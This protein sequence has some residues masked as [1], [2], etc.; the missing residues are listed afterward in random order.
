MKDNHK[1][2]T[3]ALAS[4]ILIIAVMLISSFVFAYS[5]SEHMVAKQMNTPFVGMFMRW[6]SEYYLAIAS[7]GYP[8]GYPNI[9]TFPSLTATGSPMPPKIAN[10][11]WAFFPFYPLAMAALAVVFKRFLTLTPSLMVSGVIVSNIAFFVSGY[12][13]YKL[14]QKLFG[15]RIALISTVF[16]CFWVGGV[17]FSAIYSEAL[18]M[19]LTLG[20][21]YYLEENRLSNAVLL[22]FLALLRSDGFLIFIP[23]LVYGLLQFR[24]SKPQSFKLMFSSAVVASPYLIFN[25]AGYL[26]AGGVFPV[27]LIARESNWGTYPLLTNQFAAPYVTIPSYQAFDIAGLIL[28]LIPI[29]YFLLTAE[30]IF[31][32]EK[33]TLGYWAFYGAMVY[34][35]FTDSVI[36]SVMRYAIPMLPIYWVFAKIY[37]KNRLIGVTLFGLSTAMLIIAAYFLE[38]ANIY[39]M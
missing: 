28:V 8:L 32:D 26:M 20:A 6:D 16:Y 14:T 9:H 37:T 17:F 1:V 38:T 21:F 13:F 33:M 36:S 34:V 4:R 5:T 19:A 15:S 11:L 39:F 30:K 23:F 24:N 22:G 2:L 18:F 10:H 7:H 12:F 35:L 25:I 29:V 27:Q 3:I 31:A